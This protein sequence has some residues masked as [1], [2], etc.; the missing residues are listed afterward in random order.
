MKKETVEQFLA[1]GGQVEK[2]PPDINPELAAYERRSAW[3][4]QL[5]RSGGSY[6]KRARSLF[7][8]KGA[9]VV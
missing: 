3:K 9:G 8:R 4:G 7:F 1:R 2:L 6:T 5:N